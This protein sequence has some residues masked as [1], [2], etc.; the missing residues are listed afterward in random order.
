MRL[1][2]EFLE[3]IS[4]F[5][6]PYVVVRVMS[7]LFKESPVA[8]VTVVPSL[9]QE[10]DQDILIIQGILSLS[11]HIHVAVFKQSSTTRD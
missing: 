8:L 5:N 11:M 3:L 10:F 4:F 2:D 1:I 6:C 9:F 7:L